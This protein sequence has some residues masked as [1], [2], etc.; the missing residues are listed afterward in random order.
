LYSAMSVLT[1]LWLHDYKIYISRT[2]NPIISTKS[3]FVIKIQIQKRAVGTR[4][5]PPGMR[6]LRGPHDGQKLGYDCAACFVQLTLF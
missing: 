1:E 2:N 5:A 4:V 6:K 3:E